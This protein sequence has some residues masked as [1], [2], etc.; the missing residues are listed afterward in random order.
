[1]KHTL[2]IEFEAVCS[3]TGM[4]LITGMDSRSGHLYVSCGTFKFFSEIIVG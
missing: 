3:F 1:M 4:G 2:Q